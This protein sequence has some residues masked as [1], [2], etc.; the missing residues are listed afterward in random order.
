MRPA[1]RVVR[2]GLAATVQDLGR[3]QLRHFGV[4]VAGAL[5]D[6][7]HRM[8]NW[9]VGNR[10]ESATLEIPLLGPGFE[11]LVEADIA[12][13][14]ARMELRINGILQ[15]QWQTIRVRAGDFLD[16]GG[17]VDGCRSY[18]AVTGG[19]AVEPVMGSRSTYLGGRLGGL[20]GRV[21]RVDDIL[22]QKAGPLLSRSRRLPWEPI[23]PQTAVLRAIAGPHDHWF[24]EHGADFWGTPFAVSS[25]SNRMGYRLLGPAVVRDSD[26]PA[27]IV[28]EPVIA[29]NVQVPADGQPIIVLNEQTMG[30]YTCIATVIS[31]DLWRIAQVRPGD[32]V[33]FVQVSLA[34]GQDISRQWRVFLEDCRQLLTGD[35]SCVAAF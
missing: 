35:G 9:L 32:T 3:P 31:A 33:V 26:A 1:M 30:G 18:L 16:L 29:G 2:A 13:C 28:S 17:V 25:Q 14:G 8:A 15:R 21:I 7:A 12:L 5:D 27:G 6:Y 11:M 22:P 19:F 34:R 24:Q 10:A 23:Y 20:H 4:P